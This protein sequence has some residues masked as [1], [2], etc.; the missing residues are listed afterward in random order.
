MTFFEKKT[1]GLVY[2]PQWLLPYVKYMSLVSECKLLA[3]SSDLL[4]FD[5]VE[6]AQPWLIL[7]K[8]LNSLVPTSDEKIINRQE[9]V[10]TKS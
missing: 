4:L 2:W 10:F 3:A 8:K 7:L 1:C 9:L 5:I 6:N